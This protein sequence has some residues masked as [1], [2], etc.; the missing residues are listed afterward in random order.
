MQNY[1][2]YSVNVPVP[3]SVRTKLCVCVTSLTRHV[4]ILLSC[5]RRQT[6]NGREA[7]A[8]RPQRKSETA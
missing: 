4:T 5:P 1:Q 2:N 8:P 3:H 7:K 6:T